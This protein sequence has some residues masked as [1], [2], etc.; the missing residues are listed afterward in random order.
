MGCNLDK[1][2]ID[3]AIDFHG[4]WCPGLAIGL[5]AGE[6]ALQE[7]GRSGDEEVVAVVETDMCAVDGIQSL[8][9]C[10]FGKG[11]LIHLDYGKTAFT[12][13]RR[14]DG[15]SARL[16]F[17]GDRIGGGT[18][19][20]YRELVSKIAA[21]KATPEEKAEVQEHR[22]QWTDR[23]MD[24]DLEVIFELKEAGPEPRKARILDSLKCDACGETIM[25]S[26]ARRLAGQ[27]LCAPCFE[28]KDSLF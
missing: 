4:H 23:I 19:E 28:K 25:E 17:R 21:G 14:K 1:E 5:R 22:R 3:K 26:R 8:V 7:I 13:H 10:T 2:L 9:G 24:A 12:F 27:T 6:W 15:K 16:V 11:N 20:H 18:D